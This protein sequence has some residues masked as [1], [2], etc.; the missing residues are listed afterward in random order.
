MPALTN[1]IQ[2]VT[3]HY[4][5]CCSTIIY[6]RMKW[7]RASAVVVFCCTT[8]QNK[9]EMSLCNTDE[10]TTTIVSQWNEKYESAR[11]NGEAHQSAADTA[12]TAAGKVNF[13]SNTLFIISEQRSKEHD[14]IK[15]SWCN[16]S[17]I[18][19]VSNWSRF[20]FLF[21]F[22]EQSKL[23]NVLCDFN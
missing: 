4:L 21:A 7:L 23:C 2:K 8:S 10:M 15:E 18:N 16:E 20:V 9:S 19:W 1:P 13:S 5:S 3:T 6:G 17:P 22:C 12:S 11:R 14:W